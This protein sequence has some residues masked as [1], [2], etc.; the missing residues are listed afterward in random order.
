ML[1]TPWTEIVTPSSLFRNSFILRRPRIAIFLDIIKIV[2]MFIKTIFK[3]SKNV[4]RLRNYALKCNLYVNF[5]IEKFFDFHWKNAD[6]SRT[7]EVLHAINIFFGSSLGKSITVPSFIIVGY[8][9]QILGMG[10]LFSPHP[11]AAPK[12]FILNR[13][14]EKLIIL[15]SVYH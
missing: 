8:V 12:S 7:Q 14:N 10:A 15:C 2:T 4:K 11:W 3:D 1:L 6:V 5:F 13:V 9:R